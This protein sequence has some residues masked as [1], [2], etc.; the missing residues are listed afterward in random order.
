M[1]SQ[2]TMPMEPTLQRA[3]EG[4][5]RRGGHGRAQLL[6]GRAV[7]LVSECMTLLGDALPKLGFLFTDRVEVE[8]TAR[9]SLPGNAAEVLDAGIEGNQAW[10]SEVWLET[11]ST[12]ISLSSSARNSVSMTIA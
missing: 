12:R 5:R 6:P 7:S 2:V 1:L 4:L 11:I 10:R 9:A 3:G 8:E